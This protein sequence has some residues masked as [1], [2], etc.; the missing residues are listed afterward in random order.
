M[1]AVQRQEHL[2]VHAAEALQG[3]HLAADGRPR[4]ARTPN[5]LPSRATRR[6]DLDAPL[7]RIGRR[8][9]GCAAHDHGRARLWMMPAFSSAIS[10]I[11][12]PSHS[13]WS[14]P[15][16]VIT[17]TSASITLVASSRAAQP[18]L[19]HGDVDRGVGEGR[20]RHAR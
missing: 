18:D 5:S 1:G 15:I 9:L 14:S 11:V 2:V 13:V 8:L 4:G 6:A 12:S 19:D 20:E 10:S 16:G 3:Q 17:A 7:S